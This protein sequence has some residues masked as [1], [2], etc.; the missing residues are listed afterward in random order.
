MV[1]LSVYHAVDN[2]CPQLGGKSLQVKTTHRLF[3]NHERADPDALP[4]LAVQR[5][6]LGEDLSVETAHRVEAADHDLA[7]AILDDRLRSVAGQKALEISS[8]VGVNLGCDGVHRDLQKGFLRKANRSPAFRR[9]LL[10]PIAWETRKVTVRD[11]APPEEA[12]RL[13][14]G[15]STWQIRTMRAVRPIALLLLALPSVLAAQKGVQLKLA[16]PTIWVRLDTINTWAMVPGAPMAVFGKA[17]QALKDIKLNLNV[18]DSVAGMVGN[19]GFLLS[20]S[21]AGRR[22]SSWIRC[23]EGITGPNADSW[24]ISMAILSAVEPG[25]K[26]STR[27]RTIVV[28]S[29]R[30]VSGGSA[31]QMICTSSG[32]LEEVINT[33]VLSLSQ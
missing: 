10:E 25:S 27:L 3:V 30:D 12:A 20:G 33:K 22:M 29:A 7:S 13:S 11:S 9:P 18:L 26:D 32:Q 15:R 5:R 8:I 16:G 21:F 1:D 14:P 4:Y 19:S 31:Q 17:R 24:R 6:T 23:G 28:A 2:G